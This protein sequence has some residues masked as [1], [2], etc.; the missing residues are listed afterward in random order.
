MIAE[1][2]QADA[3]RIPP[4]WANNP[5]INTKAI[6]APTRSVTDHILIPFHISRQCVCC[7]EQR[8]PLRDEVR[9]LLL[10]T[11]HLRHFSTDVAVDQQDL[12]P[13]NALRSVEV[14]VDPANSLCCKPPEWH[15]RW[16]EQERKRLHQHVESLHLAEQSISAQ[17]S[18]HCTSWWNFR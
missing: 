14:L 16:C 18:R 5:P 6:V 13:W 4:N 11:F 1:M 7:G 17:S 9:Q 15:L 3:I 12:R 10:H 2:P 8:I